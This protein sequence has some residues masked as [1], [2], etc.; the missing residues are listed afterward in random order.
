MVSQRQP[1]PMQR[2]ASYAAETAAYAEPAFAAA[3]ATAYAPEP[4][5]RPA[6]PTPPS[7]PAARAA[8]APAKAPPPV[9]DD[10]PSDADLDKMLG[11]VRENAASKAFGGPVAD[12]TPALDEDAIEKLPDPKPMRQIADEDED[13]DDLDDDIE[14][15]DIPDP[16]PIPT[17]YGG[18]DDDDLD[19]ED[20]LEQG[21]SPLKKLIVPTISIVAIGVIV[22][23]II[24]GRG[25]I[26]SL[27]PGANG[28]F[29]DMIG[30]HVAVPGDGLE[31]KLTRTAVETVANVDHVIATGVV[32]NVSDTE[33]VVPTI[34]VQLLD[35]KVQVLEEKEI[36]ADKAMLQ[37]GEAL[38]FRAVFEGAPATARTVRTEWG[39]FAEGQAR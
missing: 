35:A 1:R 32:T 31:R 3:A 18:G 19:D 15:E 8:P 9:A 2:Q 27:W 28:L 6:R 10:M 20:D 4:P 39:R 23:G 22:A 7:Q 5:P 16:D 14:P 37:P 29:Y 21:G 11:P 25:M 12:D 38:Q 34:M 36:K 13:V 26:V 30:M 24:L 33:Q 17:V